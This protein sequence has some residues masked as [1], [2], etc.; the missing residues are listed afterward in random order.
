MTV[1]VNRV[2]GGFGGKVYVP[3]TPVCAMAAYV[4]NRYSAFNSTC[5]K[6]FHILLLILYLMQ[7]VVHNLCSLISAYWIIFRPVRY[8]LSLKNCIESCGK[9]PVYHIKYKVVYYMWLMRH[10]SM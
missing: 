9:R 8:S 3:H 7:E 1:K 6:D 4:T 2:G 5:L 10:N